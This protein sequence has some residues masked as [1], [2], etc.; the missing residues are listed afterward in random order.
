[1]LHTLLTSADATASLLRAR[2]SQH[3]VLTRSE[4]GL[5]ADDR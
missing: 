5:P 1:M 4:A 3:F 2:I